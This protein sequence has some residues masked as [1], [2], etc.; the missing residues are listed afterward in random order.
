[1]VG[2]LTTVLTKKEAE[3][4]CS[5]GLHQE[6]L[7]LYQK[8]LSSTP[9]LSDRF[10]GVIQDQMRSLKQEVQES[11]PNEGKIL[12]AAEIQRIR[13]GWGANATE[14]DLLVCAQAFCQVGHYRDALP[15]IVKLLQNGCAMEKVAPLFA[16]CLAHLYRPRQLFRDL[17]PLGQKLF[18]KAGD[19]LLLYLLTAEALLKIKQP[20]HAY[21]VYRY[22]MKFSVFRQKAPKRMAAIAK[23]IRQ[24]QEAQRAKDAKINS[25]AS[26]LPVRAPSSEEAIKEF[27]VNWFTSIFKY[28]SRRKTH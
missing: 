21:V 19:Q 27:S 3:A 16:D 8:L 20:V 14:G 10:K 22:L 6:A 5:Q 12:S 25:A 11:H 2:K 17:E 13:K 9:S 4:Y 26:A 28:F 24:L 18:K 1:M 23:G 7:Q 15:E